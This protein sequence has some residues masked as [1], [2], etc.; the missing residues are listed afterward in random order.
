MKKETTYHSNL[1]GRR[2][3]S[4]G[5][6][7]QVL[8]IFW[9]VFWIYVAI[10]KLWD[11]KAFHRALLRQPFPESWADKLYISLPLGELGLA[12]LFMGVGSR[13]KNSS[14]KMTRLHRLRQRIAPPLPFL[15]SALLLLVFSVYIALGLMGYYAERPCGCASIF[16]GLSWRQHLQV[17]LALLAL[18]L[19]GAY[20][21]VRSISVPRDT[22][23]HRESTAVYGHH[24][25]HFIIIHR[26]ILY[27][28]SRLFPRIFAPFPGWAGVIKNYD[29]CATPR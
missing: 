22:A 17:N 16:T 20:L 2:V 4:T 5:S 3:Q 26:T 10:D 9:V 29:T 8:H 6:P 23:L 7:V 1:L 11:L 19:L 15:V 28:F 21:S 18:S 13:V 25:L 14:T 27:T 24:L 12:L